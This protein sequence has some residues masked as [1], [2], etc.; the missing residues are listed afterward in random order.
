[1]REHKKKET[2]K[3]K[4]R[5][6]PRI[7]L[8]VFLCVLAVFLAALAFIA[9]HDWKSPITDYDVTNPYIMPYGVTMVSAHRSG[10]GIFPENTMIAFEGCIKS[11]TFRTD[12]FEFD[13]HLTKDGQLMV[14]HD[15]T[16]DRT[17]DARQVFGVKN[18]RPEDY[19]LDELRKLNFG[20]GFTD[21]D[22][23]TPYAGL[24]G[25]SVP[26]SLRAVTLEEV[27]DY[28]E[29][30]G[31]FRYII[32]IKNK[33]ELG[34]RAADRLYLVLKERNL[35][36]KAII[37]TFNAEV[38]RYLDETY[39]DML[40][41]ASIKEVIG[42]YLDSVFERECADDY[43]GFDALQI[44]ANQFVI[45]LGTSRVTDY[46]HR[47]NIAVQ[48]WTINDPDVMRLLKEINADCVM[49]DVPDVAYRVLHDG[50]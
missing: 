12:I 18:A 22:G 8:R 42:F 27:L 6:A 33:K 2:E 44:P 48:Y 13:L 34:Y 10:G 38:T 24:T 43:Y 11:E 47:H 25:D 36:D 17:T 37:G 30:N 14:L 20:A 50:E 21:P 31:S 3:T 26:D 39:P 32:E 45:R 19:T 23:G 1:M 4:K 46:A 7:V 35:L 15:D 29:A 40:R 28:L 41:S 16:L 5:S 49:S 9:T